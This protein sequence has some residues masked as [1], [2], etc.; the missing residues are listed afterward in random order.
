MSLKFAIL[1][2]LFFVMEN[3]IA[4]GDESNGEVSQKKHRIRKN[5]KK[6]RRFVE[7]EVLIEFSDRFMKSANAQAMSQVSASSSP[8]ARAAAIRSS[9]LRAESKVLNRHSA[10]RLQTL[11]NA[12]QNFSHLRVS[13]KTV[14]ATIDE[15]KAD[16]DIK[17]VQPNYIYRALKAPNDPRY[18][19]LWAL[20]N[21]AQTVT[22]GKYVPHNPGTSG[23]DMGLEAAW[24]ITSD[25]SS[26][27]VAILDTGV[28]YDQEDLAPNMWNGGD[29][30][31]KHGYDFVNNDNDPRDLNG[32]GSH[33]AGII[34]ARGNNSVGAVGVCWRA[35][36][37]A[38]RVLDASGSGTT[39]QIVS[40]IYFAIA[41]KAKIINL[42]LG[43]TEDDASFRTAV[44][45]ASNANVIIVA[46]AGND[47]EN[48]DDA[49]TPSFPCNYSVE[50]LLCVAALDQSYELAEFS[51]YGAKTVHL[52]APGTN[53]LSTYAGRDAELTSTFHTGNSSALNWTNSGG[54]WAYGTRTL[55]SGNGNF[56]ADMLLSPSNWD[57][58]NRTYANN[59]DARAYMSFNTST[60]LSA[61]LDLGAFVDVDASDQ[62]TI[63]YAKTAVDP[64]AGAGTVL[65]QFSGA[66]DSQA[67]YLNYDLG[68]CVASS[69]TL[70]FQLKS[71]ASVSDFG[72]AIFDFNLFLL[73]SDNVAYVSLDGTS[74]AAP[75]VAGL[76]ALVSAT[77]PEYTPAEVIK[78]VK[79][80]GVPLSVLEGKTTTGKAA[81]ALG[82]L[83]YIPSVT[84]LTATFE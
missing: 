24:D 82:A 26:V 22:G 60:A 69:C 18:S 19:Q 40:G 3:S 41:Q 8:V 70:G 74:M 25:C 50:N 84:G 1:L 14:E 11:Q 55:N 6:V 76:V 39:A 17:S 10:V 32:H 47:G 54:A 28:N 62:F 65:D 37:M 30:Y 58:T 59:L 80:G 53:I 15:M 79:E 51:N 83:T 56:T 77:N 27:P 45:Q 43:T 20:K 35:N 57:G 61:T 31:P 23:K 49:K 81:N 48:N 66:G 5:L 33:V 64:F 38:V 68:G 72:V 73:L 36:L 2:G 29:A 46:A 42:S 21:T 63:A 34:G 52:A 9:I 44:T 12:N 71:D 75:E 13:G 78:A 7:G 67:G 4:Y 16:P